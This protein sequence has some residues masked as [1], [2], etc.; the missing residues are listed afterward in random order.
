M[1]V[2][3]AALATENNVVLYITDNDFSLFPEF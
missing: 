3:L 1:D 2:H